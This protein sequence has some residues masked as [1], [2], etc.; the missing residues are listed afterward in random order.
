MQDHILIRTTHGSIEV[1]ILHRTS[2]LNISLEKVMWKLELLLCS[3]W[4][5][6]TMDR[7]PLST[8]DPPT[9]EKTGSCYHRSCVPSTLYNH[10]W[11]VM[12]SSPFGMG[13]GSSSEHLL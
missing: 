3:Y 8:F 10:Y 1:Q 11:S 7:A 6:I 4:H 2:K 13:L 12:V 9:I 5:F